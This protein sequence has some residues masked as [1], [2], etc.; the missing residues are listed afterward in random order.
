MN[1]KFERQTHR[2]FP[3]RRI[4]QHKTTCLLD[5]GLNGLNVVIAPC[6]PTHDLPTGRGL[7]NSEWIGGHY[8]VEAKND[9]RITAVYKVL[10]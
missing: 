5:D 7:I 10:S 3:A 2:D 1:A 4:H 9:K 8:V 6:R